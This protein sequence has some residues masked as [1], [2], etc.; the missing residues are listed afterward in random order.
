M[1][2]AATP[3]PAVG[4]GRLGDWGITFTG[5]QFWPADPRPSDV[6]VRDIA[7]ALA[8]QNRFAGHTREP[9]SV[10]QHSVLVSHACRREHALL[11]L[12]HDSTEAYLQDLIRPLKRFLAPQYKPL[13]RRWAMSIGMAVGLG[14]V[15]VDLPDDV[16]HAD[17]LVL[18]AERRDLLPPRAWPPEQ[19]WEDPIAPWSWRDAEERFL[20]RFAELGGVIP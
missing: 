16:E 3:I 9:Y 2:A 11:G 19:A 12:L 6:D 10:A 8:L 13:E 20:A 1:T 15:L 4:A 17:R 14:D 5:R 18:V 7:H